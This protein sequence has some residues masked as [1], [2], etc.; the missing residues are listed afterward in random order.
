MSSNVTANTFDVKATPSAKA[1]NANGEHLRR[2]S[3]VFEEVRM[4]ITV[5]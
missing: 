2:E 4:E 3:N 1:A 5:R